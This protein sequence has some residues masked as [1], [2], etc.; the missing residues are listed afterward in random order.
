MQRPKAPDETIFPKSNAALFLQSI[1]S[2]GPSPNRWRFGFSKQPG[3]RKNEAI[4]QPPPTQ[5]NHLCSQ[6]VRLYRLSKVRKMTGLASLII[7]ALALAAYASQSPIL[8]RFCSRAFGP[9]LYAPGYPWASCAIA[10]RA[11]IE[12]DVPLGEII[13][14]KNSTLLIP[15]LVLPRV[16]AKRRLRQW[17]QPLAKPQCHGLIVFAITEQQTQYHESHLC[18]V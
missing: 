12:S 2:A 7:H 3:R 14:T 13:R 1:E 8:P 16:F 6:A 5:E 10:N 15:E 4:S 11:A 18:Q 17:Y 9:E